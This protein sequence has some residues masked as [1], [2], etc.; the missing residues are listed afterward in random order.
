[1]TEQA[2]KDKYLP[3]AEDNSSKKRTKRYL[4]THGRSFDDPQHDDPEHISARERLKA[5]KT[6]N[7]I[8]LTILYSTLAA[9]AISTGYGF[10]VGNFEALADVWHVAGPLI[11]GIVGFY[12][13]SR[14]DSG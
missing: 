8:A 7:H 2:R 3:E 11:G 1:M 4:P 9:L 5:G 10:Y 12:F 13:W 14:K 6:R